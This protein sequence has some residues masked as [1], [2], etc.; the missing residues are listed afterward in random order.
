MQRAVKRADRAGRTQ[1]LFRLPITPC[2]GDISGIFS[3]L[4]RKVLACQ[5]FRGKS[6][7][8]GVQVGTVLLYLIRGHE[9]S[10]TL[11]F[12]GLSGHVDRHTPARGRQPFGVL[13]SR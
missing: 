5:Q 11:C 2:T 1:A 3:V 10:C 13:A 4:G 7:R 9:L 8:P 6:F 12:P